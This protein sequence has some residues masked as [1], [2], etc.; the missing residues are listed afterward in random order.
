MAD[1]IEGS[2]S[3]VPKTEVD[4]DRGILTDQGIYMKL[5]PKCGRMF[6]PYRKFQKFCTDW[7]RVQ[8]NSKKP[9]RYQK[10]P[11]VEVQCRQCNKTFKTNDS[12]RHYCDHDCYVAAQEERHTEPE[13]R[14]CF[15]CE[16]PFRTTHFIKRYCSEE[17]RIEA[18][19]KRR[20]AQT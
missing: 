6:R 14:I 10:K 4:E 19:E 3:M 11:M 8:F 18:K 7:C 2:G 17:C 13:E 15:N 9:S 12:K 20:H 1:V 5:C 16:K